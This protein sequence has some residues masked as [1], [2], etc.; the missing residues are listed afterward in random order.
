MNPGILRQS[1]RKLSHNLEQLCLGRHHGDSDLQLE[2][3]NVYYAPP[4][5]QRGHWRAL[6]PETRLKSRGNTENITNWLSL[7]ARSAGCFARPRARY[8]RLGTLQ[9][10]LKFKMIIPS[11]SFGRNYRCIFNYNIKLHF[12]FNYKITKRSV[13]I[14]RHPIEFK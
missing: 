11:K 2:R 14:C 4:G 5:A 7:E 9:L 13:S 1:L 10:G 6:P 3:I 12:S 8:S